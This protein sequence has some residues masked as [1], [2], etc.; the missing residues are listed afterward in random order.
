MMKVAIVI[1]IGRWVDLYVMVF[2]SMLGERPTF[3]ILEIAAIAVFGIA[4]VVLVDRA[5]KAA[6]PVPENDPGLTESL[7]YHA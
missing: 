3:G 1:L 2:P 4:G 5:F 6:N 7:N